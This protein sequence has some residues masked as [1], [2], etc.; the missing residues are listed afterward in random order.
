MDT[1]YTA[2]RNVLILISLLKEHGVKKFIVSPGTTNISLVASIQQDPY[3]ELYS[4]VDERAAAYMACGLAAESG[5]PVAL[6]CTGATASRNYAPGLTEAFYR[7]LPV[8]AITAT[9]HIGRIGQN[10]AQVIDRSQQFKDMVKCS[11]QLPS[12]K[13]DEDEWAEIVSVNSALLELKHNGCGPIHINFA[14]TYN[15]D[16]SVKELPAVRKID[17]IKSG[18]TLPDISAGR[19]IVFV[20]QH[21]VFSDELTD[22]L[23]AFCACYN[24]IVLCDQTS[25]YRGKY[26]VLGSLLAAQQEQ[27]ASKNCDLLIHIGNISGA[28][29]SITAKE[30]WRVNPDGVIRDT[31]GKLRYMF[32]MDEIEFFKSYITDKIGD[33]SFLKICRDDEARIRSKIPELPFSN[34]WIASQIASKIPQYSALHLGIL[35]TLRSWNFFETPESVQVYCNTGG[36]GIDGCLSTLLGA[37]LANKNKLYFGVIGDLAFFYDMNSLGNHNL[38]KNIRLM[39]INNGIG[40]EFKN[41]NHRASLWGEDA[42][43]FMAAGGHFGNKSKELIRNYAENLGCKYL[44]ASTKEEFLTV[45]DEWLDPNIG[46]KPI[47]L[48]VFTYDHDES[49]ALRAMNTIE[50]Y[51][52]IGGCAKNIVKKM[53]GEKGIKFLK[54]ILRF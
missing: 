15:N 31:F 45:I 43:P 10:I 40:T 32:E 21:V 54:K 24:A 22:A 46:D 44:S 48:E 11:I 19:K 7:K 41:Y 52:S 26:R 49:D 20:G 12:I 27:L 1:K 37:S 5:E 42:N 29:M 4:S 16:F 34:I 18:D 14:T 33:D 39:I 3:F 30:V 28:Y 36:F 23:D 9:Q 47:V 2:E 53:I 17:R 6:S 38:G 35:N 13:T 8:I 50:Y 25:N 51:N